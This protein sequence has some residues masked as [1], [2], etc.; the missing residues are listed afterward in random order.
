MPALAIWI[1]GNETNQ[2]DACSGS[3][4]PSAVD[5]FSVALSGLWDRE[6]NFDKNFEMETLGLT[7]V[8]LVTVYS[9]PATHPASGGTWS[10]Y[11]YMPHTSVHS[12][13][14]RMFLE[15]VCS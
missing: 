7:Y 2:V 13:L 15:S 4:F 3:V 5:L 8:R 10:S 9:P 1:D 11:T 14:H 12:S 6:R